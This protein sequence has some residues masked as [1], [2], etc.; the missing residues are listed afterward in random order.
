MNSKLKKPK[1]PN[2]SEY[3]S[4]SQHFM[5]KQCL[6]QYALKYTFKMPYEVNE[7]WFLYGRLIHEY[8]ETSK[9][10]DLTKLLTETEKPLELTAIFNEHCEMVKDYLKRLGVSDKDKKEYKFYTKIKYPSGKTPKHDM[11]V[12]GLLDRRMINGKDIEYKTGTGS[13]SENKI[14]GHDQFTFYMWQGWAETGEIRPLFLLNLIK[15]DIKTKRKTSIQLKRISRT[16]D[17]FEKLMTEA[18]DLIQK[19]KVEKSMEKTCGNHCYNCP[20]NKICSQYD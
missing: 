9:V 18:E 20:F 14:A 3:W 2:N 6:R 7:Y 1:K 13:W 19:T 17:D 15:G 16:E 5:A 10:P 4:A 12:H 8:L 11:V